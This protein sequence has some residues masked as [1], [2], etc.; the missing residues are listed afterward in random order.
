[1]KG[2]GKEYYSSFSALFE[3][4]NNFQKEVRDRLLAAFLDL[5]IRR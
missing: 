3:W 5:F 2:V 4:Y 1:M